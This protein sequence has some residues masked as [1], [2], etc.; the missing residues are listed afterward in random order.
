VIAAHVVS[1]ASMLSMLAF[2]ETGETVNLGFSHPTIATVLWNAIALDGVIT[3]LLA[4]FYIAARGPKAQVPADG[5]AG[6]L[7]LPLAALLGL[8]AIA[9]E[10]MPFIDS[11]KEFAQ[12]LP[13]VTNSVVKTFALAA[14]CVYAARRELALAGPIVA[15]HALS[16]VVSAMY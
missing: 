13:F 10:V 15:V 1:V 14:L 7:L 11:T 4:W 9:Y 6:V 5:G 16:V 8:G 12:E 3:A 2:A